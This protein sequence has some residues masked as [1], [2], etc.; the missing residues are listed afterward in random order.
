MTWKASKKVL[1]FVAEIC[2]KQVFQRLSGL[3]QLSQIPW[4]SSMSLWPKVQGRAA[5]KEQFAIEH[6]H[7]AR[8]IKKEN[9]GIK[10]PQECERSS[11]HFFCCVEPTFKFLSNGSKKWLAGIESVLSRADGESTGKMKER[12]KDGSGTHITCT[13]MPDIFPS[14][15]IKSSWPCRFHLWLS[16]RRSHLFHFHGKEEICHQTCKN[17]I[18]SVSNPENTAMKVN[19]IDKFDGTNCRWKP[20]TSLHF[21]KQKGTDFTGRSKKCFAF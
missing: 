20:K 10:V 12:M 4:T 9:L 3:M 19:D 2:L 1:K 6:L 14:L 5:S 18:H 15:P 17:F 16:Q 21:L 13:Y 8:I 7:G 11:K